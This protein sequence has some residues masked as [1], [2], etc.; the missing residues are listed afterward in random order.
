MIMALKKGPDV[1]QSSPAVSCSYK[2]ELQI[3]GLIAVIVKVSQ[4][5][6][7]SMKVFVSNNQ[8]YVLPN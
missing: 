6:N 4:Q 5:Y 1:K 3:Q 7:I 2:K 8:I